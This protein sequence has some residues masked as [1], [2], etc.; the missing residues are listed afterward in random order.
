LARSTRI[1]VAAAMLLTGTSLAMAKIRGVVHG[2]GNPPRPGIHETTS[3]PST[4]DPYYR[5]SDRY[6]GYSDPYRGVYDFYTVPP[7]SPGYTY[8]HVKPGGWQ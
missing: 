5:L 3:R 2:H 8:G 7:Y 4:A 1:A 6:Y